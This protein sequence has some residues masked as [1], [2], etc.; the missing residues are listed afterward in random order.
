MKKQHFE[1]FADC[2]IRTIGFDHPNLLLKLFDSTE[3]DFYALSFA[4]VSFCLFESDHLQNVISELSIF[5][6]LDKARNDPAFEEFISA[7]NIAG[8]LVRI[9]G[10][11][12]VC[13]IRPITGG[14]MVI[15]FSE[16]DFT[17]K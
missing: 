12:Q 9:I 16:C 13:Y 4:D 8:E 14:D 17:L 1:S 15:V 7:K 10:N 5:D 11:Y 2:E 6:S 3:V